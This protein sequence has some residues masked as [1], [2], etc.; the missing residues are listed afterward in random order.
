MKFGSKLWM[1]AVAMATVGCSDELEDGPNT[2]GGEQTINGP[3]TYMKVSVVQGVQTR[4]TG[5][6]EG[7]LTE[8]E[9]GED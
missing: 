9:T 4:A 8:G 5:G 6:E 7:D 1:L 3:K 2:Q